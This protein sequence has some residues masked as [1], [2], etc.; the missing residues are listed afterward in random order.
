MLTESSYIEVKVDRIFGGLNRC[1]YWTYKAFNAGLVLNPPK[2]YP[3]PPKIRA[4]IQKNRPYGKRFGLSDIGYIRK[5][6]LI[7]KN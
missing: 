3:K 7:R 2:H 6:A 5:K 1:F 4:N